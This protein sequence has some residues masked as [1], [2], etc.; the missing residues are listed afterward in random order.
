MPSLFKLIHLFY[1]TVFVFIPLALT[2][3]KVLA[4]NTIQ[5][6]IEINQRQT[7]VNASWN[8]AS[9]I[10][11]NRTPNVLSELSFKD[12]IATP[13]GFKGEL[14][15][16]TRRSQWRLGVDIVDGQFNDGEVTD[17]DYGGDNRTEEW[18]RSESEIADD[19]ISRVKA[20]IG[21]GRENKKY[22]FAVLAGFNIS[23]Q[24][25]RMQ[26]GEQLLCNSSCTV[27][28]GE[29]SGLDSVYSMQWQGPWV[30][31]RWA[32]T[33]GRHRVTVAYDYYFANTYRGE[34]EWNLRSDLQQPLS[35]EHEADAQGHGLQLSYGFDITAHWRLGVLYEYNRWESKTGTETRYFADNT[36][37]KI[38]LN[39]AESESRS[40]G[41][42]LQY[43]F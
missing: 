3:N 39:K 38:Q 25:F 29:F 4:N 5:T 22:R 34:A 10:T 21:W 15:L 42:G 36:I 6:S 40:Y 41:I 43:T 7:S 8:T 18:S 2:S 32:E 35:F 28:I 9:D 26:N 33:K 1:L 16:N 23:E 19:D 13:L 31:A 12:V 20:Y 24:S 37:G 30:G 11:G 17:S 14:R 27:G